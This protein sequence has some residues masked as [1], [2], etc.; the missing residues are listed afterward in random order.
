M[1]TP[2]VAMPPTILMITIGYPPDQVGGTEVFVEGLVD[3]L[4]LAGYRCHVAYLDTFEDAKAP[5]IRLTD[6]SHHGTPV[7]VVQA[8]HAHFPNLHAED[9]PE[10]RKAVLEGFDRVVSTVRPDLVHLHPLVLGFESYLVEHLKSRGLPVI[11]TFHSSTTSCARGDLVYLGRQT[12][13]GKILP[14]RCADCWYHSRGVPS[15]VSVPLSR[16][17]LPVLRAGETLARWLPGGRR[18][19]SVL[20]V[21]GMIAGIGRAWERAMGGADAVVAVCHWVREVLL[22]N[23]VPADKITLS[24]HGLRPIP[25]PEVMPPRTTEVKFGYVGRISVEKGIK[26]LVDALRGIPREVP[27]IFE[28][29]SATFA[30]ARPSSGAWELCERIRQAAAADDRIR[31]LGAVPTE[32]LPVVLAS[33]D[34]LVVPSLWFESGPQVVYESFSVQ[35]PVI[36]SDRGGIPELVTHGKTGFLVPPD[37]VQALRQALVDA[38]RDPAPLRQLRNNIGPVRTT[39]DLAED[40]HRL[41]QR[42]LG[43]PQTEFR[44]VREGQG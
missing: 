40:M 42:V 17:P 4:Q 30:A 21:P 12:C 1:L 7:H 3:Q 25:V 26:V 44:P 19:A 28:F 8:N 15:V 41:Y 23:G 27:F 29:C 37:D 9:V 13:D 39:R 22:C 24:R 43:R 34:A 14:S 5:P 20:R 35:T 38:A 16:M 32:Q 2:D 18:L 31:I 33:W 6:R 36:G 10:A 11:L